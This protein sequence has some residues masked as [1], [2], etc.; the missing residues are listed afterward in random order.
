M[1]SEL[2]RHFDDALR[3][4]VARSCLAPAS[5]V[6]CIISGKYAA[7]HRTGFPT[8][9]VCTGTQIA[10]AVRSQAA[11]KAAM[12]LA[13]STCGMSPSRITAPSLS[14]GSAARPAL[15]RGAQAFLEG[16]DY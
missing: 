13:C 12:S 14:G 16:A 7:P 6:S 15:K 9:P 5:P 4:A 2:D 11:S 10:S 8:L 3:D 1:L